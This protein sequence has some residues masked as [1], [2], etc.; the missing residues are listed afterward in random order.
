LT[1]TTLV[2]LAPAL[3]VA[4]ETFEIDS[5]HSRVGFA[6]KHMVVATVR[7]EFEAFEG[8]VDVDLEELTNSSVEVTI[9]ATSVDTG[10]AD[11]DEHLRSADFFDVANHPRLTFETTAIER[12]GDGLVAVGDLTIRG[13]TKPVRMPIEVAGPIQDPWGNTRLG[14]S[15]RLTIDRTDFGLNYNRALEAGGLVVGREVD[16]EIDVELIR[17]GG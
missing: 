7:G 3:P 16:V 14:V 8:A 4:A 12:D 5:A 1:V 13:V 9:D 17:R 6:V 15:G 10:E 11:R 2:A